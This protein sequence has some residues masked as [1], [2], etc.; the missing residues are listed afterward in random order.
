[1]KKMTGYIWR[2]SIYKNKFKCLCGNQV[3]DPET[4]EPNG[5][6]LFDP[7]SETLY[8]NK[9]RFPICFVGKMNVDDNVKPGMHGDINKW[10]GYGGKS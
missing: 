5:D 8:C 10:K 1:M 9:C 7:E 6:L 3:A 4:G 2:E